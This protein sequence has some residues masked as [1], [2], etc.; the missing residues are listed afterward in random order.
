MKGFNW[1]TTLRLVGI[2]LAITLLNPILEDSIWDASEKNLKALCN[3]LNL[4]EMLLM[5]FNAEALAMER[6]Q[7]Y[8]SLPIILKK[9]A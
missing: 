1:K 9:Q 8:V 7:F 5:F 3:L 4:S 2:S 6:T